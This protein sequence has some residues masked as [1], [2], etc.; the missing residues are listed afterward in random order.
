MIGSV[1]SCSDR[2]YMV[3]GVVSEAGESMVGRE[4]RKG[5]SALAGAQ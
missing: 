1:I 3:S 2:E 5:Q 4:E